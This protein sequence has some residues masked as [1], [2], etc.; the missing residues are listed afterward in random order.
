MI[1]SKK[2][3]AAGLATTVSAVALSVGA[4]AAPASAAGSVDCRGA[5]H[6]VDTDRGIA[7]C[8]NNSD[9]T[10]RFRAE[11]VCGRAPDVSGD[12]VTLNPGQWG[13]SSA[14]CAWYRRSDPHDMKVLGRAARDP[15]AGIPGGPPPPL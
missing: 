8:T 6:G 1:R 2:M 11:V 13:Q 15:N 9:R 14:T 5:V 7:S 3:F 12:W 4:M 10:I